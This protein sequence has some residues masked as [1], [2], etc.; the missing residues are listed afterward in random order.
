MPYYADAK[1]IRLCRI[2]TLSTKYHCGSWRYRS[3]SAV[4]DQHCIFELFYWQKSVLYASL[5]D[6]TDI[7]ILMGNLSPTL[8]P[9]VSS[10]VQVHEGFR[11]EHALTATTI[12]TEVQKLMAVKNTQSVTVVSTFQ[13]LFFLSQLISRLFFLI[14]R[15]LAWWC[16]GR[17]WRA[18]FCPQ[19]TIWYLHYRGY[20][21]NSPSRES[22][23]RRFI[24]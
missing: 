12:L 24:R 17:T 2:F 6:L 11:D 7:D 3:Y 21:W 23:L 19:S 10:S 14:D 5:S 20:L 8:F 16:F 4:S 9:G 15:S 22:R 13:L 1:I 18:L